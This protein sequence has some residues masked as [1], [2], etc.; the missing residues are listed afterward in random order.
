MPQPVA[1]EYDR[2][3]VQPA[4]STVRTGLMGRDSMPSRETTIGFLR[5]SVWGN[6]RFV[7]D[8]E[9]PLQVHECGKER[10]TGM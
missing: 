9:K 7:K 2:V 3:H 4:A 5:R 10:L 1:C 8:T 6:L